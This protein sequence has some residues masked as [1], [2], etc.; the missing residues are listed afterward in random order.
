M[1]ISLPFVWRW[2]GGGSRQGCPRILE[3][4]RQCPEWQ[5]GGFSWLLTGCHLPQ[6]GPASMLGGQREESDSSTGPCNPSSNGLGH[7]TTSLPGTKWWL[8]PSFGSKAESVL[9]GIH[10]S[11]KSSPVSAE[12]WSEGE[13]FHCLMVRKRLTIFPLQWRHY[14]YFIMFVLQHPLFLIYKNRF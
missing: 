14:V 8:F 5:A 11:H 2:S 1:Q 12:D 3:Q 13:D 7:S 10:W 4:S 9:M 6:R